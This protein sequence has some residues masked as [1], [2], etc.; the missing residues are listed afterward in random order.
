M[1]STDTSPDTS[2]P[3]SG[4]RLLFVTGCYRSGTTLL[5]KLLHSHPQAC[6]ASQPFPVLYFMVKEA[7]LRERGLERRYPLDHLFLEDGYR[8]AEFQ[9]FLDRYQL[10]RAALD[11]LFGRLEDYT[12]GHWTRGVLR[13]RD[14]VA[15]G[16]FWQVLRSLHQLTA[17]ELG[18]PDAG[19]IGSK[20]VLC[21]EYV[22]FLL[23]H[24]ARC[25]L[26]LRDP[27]DMI[28]SLDFRERD[29]LTGDHRPLLY[30]LRLWRKSAAFA[31]A[32]D[33]QPGF[34]WLRYE[35]LVRD[36]ASQL[37]AL[38]SWMELPG[39][40]AGVVAG[41]IRGQ[42]GSR[43]LSNSSFGDQAGVSKASVGRYRA[44]LPDDV[45]AACEALCAPEM[46]ALG[47][48][49]DGDGA[50]SA[51][52]LAGFREPLAPIHGKFPP[53]YSHHPERIAAE[54]ERR[55]RLAPGAPALDPET[56]AR[57]FVD[58]RAYA[59]LRAAAPGRQAPE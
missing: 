12:N 20:E 37:A 51:E 50:L 36:P 43:W 8:A 44:V 18:R 25:A 48:P 21:E 54:V 49:L 26:I 3:E 38:S 7:F 4:G 35:D 22:P 41:E 11:E 56:A 46:Q 53:D 32:L 39:Y 42:D 23:A 5:E 2:R 16:S 9:T 52:R 58:P 24:G 10:D 55:R 13:L 6:V 1:P 47:Y 28:T 14:A 40:P 30:S 59:A 15:P 17:A 19:V 27:R 45:R 31:L 29:N 33:G 57:W 34:H